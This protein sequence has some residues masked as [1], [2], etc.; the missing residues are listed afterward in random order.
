MA[1]HLEA[2][3]IATSSASVGSR[4]S[5]VVLAFYLLNGDVALLCYGRP[6]GRWRQ[7]QHASRATLTLTHRLGLA[8]EA[9]RSHASRQPE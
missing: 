9:P 2:P 4:R 6:N 8:C 5:D 1:M 3:F 7:A